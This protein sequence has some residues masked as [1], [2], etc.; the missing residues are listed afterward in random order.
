MKT[1]AHLITRNGESRGE[2]YYISLS[3]GEMKYKVGNFQL[4]ANGVTIIA[5]NLS[6]R[7]RFKFITVDQIIDF[8]PAESK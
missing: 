5:R 3:S 4:A 2:L 1:N 8:I 7:N 6:S